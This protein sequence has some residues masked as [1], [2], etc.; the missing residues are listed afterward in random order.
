MMRTAS[1]I[2]GMC[3]GKCLKRGRSGIAGV[4]AKASLKKWDEVKEILALC[5]R[6][7][8]SVKVL[9]QRIVTLIGKK[10]QVRTGISLTV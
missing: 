10:G 5:A 9:V 7:W 3:W 6:S 4:H 2:Q 8:D 1:E